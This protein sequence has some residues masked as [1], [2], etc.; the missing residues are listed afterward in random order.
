MR[1]DWRKLNIEHDHL[2]ADHERV[3]KA[4]AE[5]RTANQQLR[6]ENDKLK[7]D[8]RQLAEEVKNLSDR[9]PQPL[10]VVAKS[11]DRVREGE[12]SH[13]G[14]A[15][16]G[17]MGATSRDSPAEPK[18][19]PRDVVPGETKPPEII[20]PQNSP[21]ATQEMQP[22]LGAD[23]LE[24]TGFEGELVAVVEKSSGL[25]VDKLSSF[26]DYLSALERLLAALRES[27]GDSARLCASWKTDV[28]W[29][30]KVLPV[31]INGILAQTEDPS[32]RLT[33]GAGEL[34]RVFCAVRSGKQLYGLLPAARYWD[35]YCTGLAELLP[36]HEDDIGASRT[37]VSSR[38]RPLV[39]SGLGDNEYQVIRKLKF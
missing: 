20:Q 39:L 3:E 12:F 5:L 6:T 24:P 36:V 38:Q 19:S 22:Q 21:T 1:R 35:T 17:D 8:Y 23:A 2:R 28:S 26:E 33:L 34:R 9:I 27:Y 15:Q 30:W 29:K 37:S 18:G 4:F 10:P 32:D 14:P 16:T 7:G 11:S 25:T 13:S 31:R